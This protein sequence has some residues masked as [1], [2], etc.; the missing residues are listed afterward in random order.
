MPYLRF[1]VV[2]LLFLVSCT[3]SVYKKMDNGDFDLIISKYARTIDS[4]D[5]EI[6]YQVAEAYRKS[7][8]IQESEPY[9]EHAVEE[10]VIEQDAYYY[11]AKALKSNMKYE[12]A[13][14]VLEKNLSRVTNQT[15]LKLVE[16]EIENLKTVDE[17][18]EAEN[19]YRAKNL[20]EINTSFADYGPVYINEY[21]YFTS[22]R[23]GGKIYKVTGTPFLDI[24]RVRS[25]GA[26]I[27]AR[28]LQKLDP[29]INHPNINEG[30]LAVSADGQSIIFAKGND[31]KPTGNLEVN[32]YFTRYR[33]GQWSEPRPIAMN[34]PKSWDSTPALTP[35]GNTL[36]FSS[37]RPGGFGGMDLYTA[38]LNRRGRWVDVRN[39]GPE[40][41]TPGNEAYPF[42]SED[43]SLYFSSDGHPGFGKI[44]IFKA[45]R[46]SGLTQIT[47]LGQPMNSEAD[48]FA[49]YEFNITK[50]F[51]SSNRKG[52]KGDDDIY[53]FVNDDPDLKIVNYFLEGIT[54][55]TDDAGDT[56]TVS[57]SKVL[58]VAADE[59]VLDESFADQN[60]KFQFRVYPEE[61]YYLIAEKTDYFTTRKVFSTI[62]KSVPKDTLT[63]FITNVTFQ[64]DIMLDRIVIEKPIVLNNIYY[65]LD[66]AEIR[67]DAAIVLDSLVMIMN[68]NPDIF[69]E[70]GSHTDDRASDDYNM[71]LSWRRARSAVAYIIQSGIDAARIVAKGYGES[72]LLIQNAQTEEEHQINRRTEFKVLRYDPKLNND[73]LPPAEELDEYD[74]FFND[75]GGR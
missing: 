58:L 15:V 37:T 23:S 69:V 55:T 34:D 32:L 3:S 44:D 51:F 19:Y 33:N 41:N 20:D 35:D 75:S 27:N 43:G 57:N 39:L 8:R 4:N 45:S 62:G 73:D 38:K 59:T 30:S 6:N 31:G 13:R 24:Y 46:Q 68:D 65:D 28:T 52:G 48:D 25:R 17:L 29:I 61:E 60:G 11:Y 5:P 53:T 70:L 9:Y 56:I 63:E 7:N 14:A 72:N 71:D 74:R 16:N 36:Y 26:N 64:S 42:I 50:G 67:P 54:Q 10:G 18:K 66:K 40:I 1:L 47:N 49:Y 21:L 12:E 2:L 22:N